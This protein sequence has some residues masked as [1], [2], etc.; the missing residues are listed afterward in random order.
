MGYFFDR[1]LPEAERLGVTMAMHP[2]DPPYEVPIRGIPNLMRS[3]EAFDR[4]FKLGKD[5]PAL[6]MEFCCGCWLEG[7]TPMGNLLKNIR[8]F[9]KRDKIMNI[10]LRNVD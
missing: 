7:A 8:E 5:S 9:I 3:K 10:H 2:N 6:K 1:V 4:I